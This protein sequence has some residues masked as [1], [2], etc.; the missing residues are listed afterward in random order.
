MKPTTGIVAVAL[1]LAPLAALHAADAPAKQPNTALKPG[2]ALNLESERDITSLTMP[3]GPGHAATI[4]Q[5]TSGAILAAW[6]SGMERAPETDIWMSRYD[7]DQAAWTA[8]YRVFDGDEVAKGF[9]CENCMLFQPRNGPV[10]LFVLV[11]GAAYKKPGD[12]TI[13]Y[14]NLRG[15]LKTSSDD[16]RTWSPP[17]ALGDSAD[18][19]GGHLIGPTKNA[20]IQLDDGTILV[21][22]SSEYGLL[23]SRSWGA[24]TYHFEKSTDHGETWQFVFKCAKAAN[25]AASHTMQPGFLHLGDGRLM[26]LGR[27]NTTARGRDQVPFAASAD[28]GQTWS[29]VTKSPNLKH[30]KTGICPLTLSDGTHACLVNRYPGSSERDELDLM[31]SADGIHWS[32][33]INVQGTD[34]KDAHYPQAVQ[35]ADGKLHVVYSYGVHNKPGIIR[36]AVIQTGI[37]I[38]PAAKATYSK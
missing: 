14:H 36:H 12:N 20:P 23:E 26:A 19:A 24:I 30:N 32:L 8:P 25:L 15:Y 28:N 27:D 37:P 2:L 7:P 31:V 16:G 29:P 4:A 17:K 9:T 1:L 18:V 6:W 13:Y 22:S 34:G 3:G 33:G 11:G 35:T 21:G 5:T 10:M 38:A